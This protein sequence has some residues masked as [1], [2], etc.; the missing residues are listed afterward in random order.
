MGRYQALLQERADLVKRGQ[1]ILDGAEREGRGLS[2]EERR[3]FDALGERIAGINGDL[4][5]EEQ[6]RDWE[7][8]LTAV[9]D[10]NVAAVAAVAGRQL[11]DLNWGFA[12]MADFAT[13]VRRASLP[14]GRVDERLALSRAALLD[15]RRQIGAAAA[16]TTYHQET[17]ADEGYMVPPAMRDSIWTLVADGEY[18]D[19]P[20]LLEMTSPEPTSSNAVELL[21]DQTTPWG[22][23]GIQAYWRAEAGLMT[24][25]KLDTDKELV[26]LFELYA[27][28]LATEELL[29][30]APRLNSRLIAGAAAAIRYKINA[31]LVNG[32]GAGTPLGWMKA[33]ALVSVAKET[34]QAAATLVAANI[35]KMYARVINPGRSVW[36][37]NQDVLPQLLTMTL[38]NQPIWTRPD[39]G[40]AN[41]PGGFLFGRPIFFSEHNETL[42]IKGDVQLI[43][44]RGYYSTRR[45]EGPQ[46]AES[47][48]LYFDYNIR[49][50]RWVFRLGGQ[51]FLS[52]PVSPKNGAATRSH[53]VTLDTRA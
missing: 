26:R 19:G 6:R 30:D 32:T 8:A 48:H 23:T 35:A 16:P 52:A 11:D 34:G 29:A 27:F 49:A 18:D 44:P 2:D 38:S 47:I 25:S 37:I 33:A 12:S 46:F 5:R 31:A 36:L 10:G 43:N 42:G 53:F 4:A 13:A 1:T 28:V 41:A 14:G 21:K 22:S 7:R 3:E 20:N 40:F 45:Q 50:F 39:S 17:G 24:A 9:P 15:E 51:P